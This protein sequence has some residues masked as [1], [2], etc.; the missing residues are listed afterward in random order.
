ML[1]VLYQDRPFLSP[2]QNALLSKFALKVLYELDQDP[3][4]CPVSAA[5]VKVI[6]RT[7][8]FGEKG[9]V[10]CIPPL[11]SVLKTSSSS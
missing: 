11:G 3:V 10:L 5:E 7:I 4:F 8:I 9:Q 1:S 2:R 6:F